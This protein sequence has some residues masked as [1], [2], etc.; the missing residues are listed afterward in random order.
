[1]SPEQRRKVVVAPDKFKGS[2]TASQVAHYVASVIRATAAGV[3]VIEHPLADGG[4][5]S[6]DVALLSGL[7]PI[8]VEVSGPM[9]KPVA[10]TYAMGAGTAVIEAS[11]AAGL[12]QLRGAPDAET[13]RT[14]S[15]YGVGQLIG[16]ALDRGAQRI[17]LGLGGSAT[18]DGGAGLATA[19]GAR[20]TT[21]DGLPVPRGGAALGLL[22]N[23]NI[24]DLDPRLARTEFVLACDVDNPL[25]GPNGAAAV[26]G[27]QKGADPTVI[28]V[29]DHGLSRWAEVLAGVCG[30]DR[31]D[32]I[33]AGAAG[34]TGFALLMLANARLASGIRQ[35][36]ELSGFAEIAKD[37]DLLVVGEGSLD[38]QSLHGK[39]PVGVAAWARSGGCPSGMKIVAVVGRNELTAQQVDAAGMDAVYSLT[40]IE[41]RAEV[42]MTQA[43]RLVKQ[44]T[45]QIIADW[46]QPSDLVK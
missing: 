16:D 29:L 21:A 31:R 2:L 26:F 5:G 3:E 45:A 4:E 8:T 38:E 19:L 18:T 27:P 35:F 43:D 22:A 13:A 24:A 42:C 20:L 23:L 15:T 37:A 10:A 32:G 40:D 30:F 9:G 34:G 44:L 39:G 46:L 17:V 25:T 7:R 1:V 33:G 41:P 12:T 36:M 6:V 11:A 14:S 28:E